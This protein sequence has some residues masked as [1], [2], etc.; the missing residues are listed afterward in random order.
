MARNKQLRAFLG[1]LLIASDLAMTAAAFYAAYELRLA[2]DYKPLA[3]IP[4]FRLYL[5]MGAIQVISMPV[6]FFFAKLYHI[7]RAGSRIDEFYSV[8]GA[9]SVGTLV[10]TS[11]TSFVYKG[12]L[13]YPRLMVIYA[14][15]LTILLVMVGRTLQGLLVSLLRSR[16]AGADRVLIVGT[17]EAGRMLLQKVQNAPR[18]G[19]H[20]VG[21]IDGYA[22]LQELDGLPVLG[23]PQDIG[24]IIDDYAIDAVL[25]GL[26]E[27]SREQVMAAISQCERGKVEIK[28][29]PD[30]FQ[31]IASELSIGE[32]DGLPMLTV[33][34]VALRGW[35]LSLKRGFDLVLGSVLLVLSSP[36]L[37]FLA[38]LV[39][40][41]S[42]G[43][44]LYVQERV[45]L[46][47]RPFP[48]V[49]FRT[50]CTDAEGASGPVW[51]KAGDPR[52]TRLGTFLRKHS[53]DELPQL[54]NV[55]LGEMSL[56]GPRPERPVFVEQF[57]QSIPRY[58]DRHREKAGMA[59][60]AQINGL[61]GDTSIE[62][63]TK[64]DLW[65]VENWSLL[66]DIKILVRAVVRVFRDPNAA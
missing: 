12:N 5:G 61:R 22:G 54:I 16:G 48:I 52:R 51:A 1:L 36:F 46:D 45:G 2:T 44:A 38:A 23:S 13:D 60:W 37:L 26:P 11:V 31:L 3:S 34:D 43:P 59:G 35:R 33:R 40:L 19:Y 21:F 53:L 15:V 39:K 56:V 25:I 55:V 65:Y 18:L 20:V 58:M 42:P 14:W 4:A 62:E 28:V 10:S 63:R 57:R 47:A 29:L 7:K 66:L 24:Q 64:Y 6:V 32:L 30:V 50:M 17:G 8:F 27:A 9:V 41:E 49:K